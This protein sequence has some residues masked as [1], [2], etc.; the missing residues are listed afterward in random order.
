MHISIALF[1]S[2]ITHPILCLPSYLPS[3]SIP[4]N[5]IVL[6][7]V[8]ENENENESGNENKFKDEEKVD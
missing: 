8:D 6:R 5:D 2:F 1:V 3:I 7:R 4:I